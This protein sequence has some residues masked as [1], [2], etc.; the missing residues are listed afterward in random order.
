MQ[1]TEMSEKRERRGLFLWPEL[2]SLLYVWC[3][4]CGPEGEWLDF[5]FFI[6][7][8]KCRSGVAISAV[9]VFVVRRLAA[10]SPRH[11]STAKGDQYLP[12][13]IPFNCRLLNTLPHSPFNSFLRF[14]A[15]QS[16]DI[17]KLA[18]N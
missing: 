4:V 17:K 2:L 13:F 14:V 12:F 11:L 18:Q 7:L 8:Q 10:H 9:R 5:F 1:V 6:W 3:L 15:F 16:G